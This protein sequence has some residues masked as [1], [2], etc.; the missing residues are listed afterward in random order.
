[1][2]PIQKRMVSVSTVIPIEIPQN[3]G[4]SMRFPISENAPKKLS[5]RRITEKNVVIQKL[6][7][8]MQLILHNRNRV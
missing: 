6:R 2:M 8:R 7:N 3:L 5:G 4:F 1:M